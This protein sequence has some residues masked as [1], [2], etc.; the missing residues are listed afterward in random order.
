MRPPIRLAALMGIQVAYVFTHDSLALGEDG[1]THQSVEHVAS[2][3]A[4]P[5]LT[6]IRPGDANETAVAWRV[7]IETRDRPVALILTRQHVP[8]QRGVG[9]PYDRPSLSK[10]LWK[11]TAHWT[12]SGERPKTNGSR[13]ILVA[14][15]RK[16]FHDSSV[17]WT[18]RAKDSPITHPCRPRSL[19]RGSG[20]A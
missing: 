5:Q 19:K 15:S 2:L 8:T 16:F 14:S 17:S 7:A 3:R 10:A 12:A 13:C 18:T 11:D 9:A 4:I 6:V 20:L 1:P